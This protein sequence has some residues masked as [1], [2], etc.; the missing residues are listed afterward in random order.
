MGGTHISAQSM[1]PDLP[2]FKEGLVEI[3]LE[4]NGV[5]SYGLGSSESGL[6]LFNNNI[7]SWEEIGK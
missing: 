4:K 2:S 6:D 3:K 1:F 7:K 5:L